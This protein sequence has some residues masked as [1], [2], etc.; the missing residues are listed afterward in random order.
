[1][2]TSL[3]HSPNPLLL[4]FCA[5]L[6]SFTMLNFG[7]LLAFGG[8]F[9]LT[10]A[11]PFPQTPTPTEGEDGSLSLP[12]ALPGATEAIEVDWPN[13]TL[14]CTGNVADCVPECILDP[15]DP[16]TWVN[17]G[18]PMLRDWVEKNGDR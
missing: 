15:E 14:A 10:L 11:S 4:S 5:F 16:N 13:G 12:V 8:L 9:G 1:M 3:L 17:N 7:T 18:W 2:V 6:L